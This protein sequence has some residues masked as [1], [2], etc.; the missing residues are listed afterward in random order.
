MA[1]GLWR[2][3]IVD[4]VGRFAERL[5]VAVRGHLVFEDDLGVSPVRAE[6]LLSSASSDR[7]KRS[8]REHPA[9]LLGLIELYQ[10]GRIS[11]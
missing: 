7:E 1:C 11:R 5:K 3:G 6:A 2:R 4:D 9:G 10:Q 8:A